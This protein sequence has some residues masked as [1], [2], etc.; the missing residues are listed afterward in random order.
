[1]APKLKGFPAAKYRVSPEVRKT[2]KVGA[3]IA[4]MHCGRCLTPV[5]AAVACVHQAGGNW[6]RDAVRLFL[7]RD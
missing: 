7:F 2:D 3:H 4:T 1:M 5:E 6:S